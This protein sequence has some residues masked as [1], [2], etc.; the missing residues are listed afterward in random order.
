MAAKRSKMDEEFKKVELTEDEPNL[1]AD[2]AEEEMSI[3]EAAAQLAKAYADLEKEQQ[4]LLAS[5]QEEKEKLLRLQADFDNFRR[6]TRTEKEDWRVQIVA[7]IAAD[8]LPV[9]DNF[10]RAADAMALD[11]KAAPHL[12]GVEMIQRQLMEVLSNRGLKPVE[13]LGCEFDP[14]CHEAVAEVPVQDADMAG[15][16]VDEIQVGYKVGEKLLRP[17][18]VRVGKL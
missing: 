4:A 6:R 11:E 14:N 9:L 1:A 18:M 7:D 13:A 3:E 12:A 8:F 10:Q 5:Y 16:V 2:E 15:K 17:S